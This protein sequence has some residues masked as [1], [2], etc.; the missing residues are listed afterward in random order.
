MNAQN[1]SHLFLT[2]PLAV[3]LWGW[4]GSIFQI[5]L[6]TSIIDSIFSACNGQWSPQVK[7][8]LIAAIIHTINTVWFCRNH[9]RFEDRNVTFL[10]AKARIKSATA[11]SGNHSKLLTNKSVLSFVILREFNIK[12][13]FQKAPRIKE[14]IW[15]AP[16]VGWIKINTDGAA[17]GSP[18][19][20]G[21]GSIFHFYGVNDSL[22]VELQAALKAIE[23]VYHKGWKD[24]W[25]E[26][27]SATVV[28]IFNGNQPLFLIARYRPNLSP[29]WAFQWALAIRAPLKVISFAW[30]LFLDR[31]PTCDALLR[32]G[33]S[34]INGGGALCSLCNDQLESFHHL[35]FSCSFS[36]SV[37]Q[38]IYKWLDIYVA[39]PLGPIKHFLHH[40]GMIKDRKN[41]HVW[42]IIW[43]VTV[44]ALWRS[45]NDSIFNNVRLSSLQILDA[46]R[47]NAWLWII[48]ILEMN[49]FAYS[50]WISKPLDSLNISL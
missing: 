26:C 24:I 10:Q 32:R 49:Y 22:Y 25:L 23:N 9:R 35:F 41:R 31:V 37:W 34:L 1:S 11:L 40:L 3:Q 21:G 6:D 33:V 29:I 7:G 43:L 4:L 36:Y 27:D 44:W 30:R 16:I 45:R 18:G 12:P 15:I 28:D 50:D 14:V 13:N 5:N 17:H 48:N 38:L 19:P 47:V 8:V 46:A 42:S 2:C 20:A 39:L